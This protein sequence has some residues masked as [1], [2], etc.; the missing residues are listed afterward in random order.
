MQVPS[1]SHLNIL[2][3]E[4]NPGDLFL[5]EDMLRSTQLRI[6]HLY[7]ADRVQQA[8]E[9]I[10]NHSIHLVLLDLSLPDSSGL[11]SFMGIRQLTDK[12]PVII[13]TGLSD[14]NVALEA[15]KNGAQDYLIKGEFNKN[16]L[17]K[18]IQYSLER[19]YQ[20]ENLWQSNE[21]FN[22]VVRATN[23]AIWDRD[24]SANTIYWVGD[25]YKRLFGH[26]VLD[27][28]APKGQWE[29]FLHPD[30]QLRV[31]QK[32]SKTIR[33]GIG[34]TWEDLYRLRKKDGNYAYVHDR[35]YIIYDN[36]LPVRMIGSTQDI[37]ERKRV[38]EVVLASEAKYRQM[39]YR[40]PYPAWIYDAESL[41]ILEVND[42]AIDTYG[43][44]RDEF[45][46]LNLSNIYLNED[47]QKL[48][49]GNEFS[50]PLRTYKA[51]LWRHRKKSGET[52]IA[53]VTYYSI[54]YFGKNAVQEHIHDITEERRLQ[55][56][57]VRQQKIKRQQI[58]EAVLGAQEKE[59]SDIGRELHDNINQ[60]LATSKLYL[61]V[62]LEEEEDCNP[63]IKKSRKNITLAIE[64]I[65]KISKSLITPV[66]DDVGLEQSI[67][68]LTRNIHEVKKMRFTIDAKDL[69]EDLLTNDQKQ[70][71]YRIVQEQLNNILKHADAS[72][73]NIVLN[74]E[75]EKIF[76]FIEDNGKGFNVKNV[77]KG[78][79][80]T[81]MMSR[82]EVFNGKLEIDSLPGQ[83]CRLK[84][85]LNTKTV[86][87]QSSG[88]Q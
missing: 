88:L 30:D 64:E 56:Q 60:I 16:L 62:I 73:V 31:I 24:L 71:L 50:Y 6:D 5:V 65:R 47:L 85:I 61:D 43:Y 72:N 46:N 4:D 41:Q 37:T 70:A 25:S 82:A 39:F 66:L 2:T 81:N 59:R 15:I 84:V 87:P 21:R 27:D 35:G 75:G 86:M 68:E 63:L 19:K 67:K 48:T 14:A 3:V 74:T 13:L 53:E 8:C 44:S 58:T 11:D 12:I 69:D 38:E 49:E 32:L 20:M 51:K 23:D 57:L 40:N 80:I 45:M 55:K 10:E 28:F 83:G 34:N 79:G 76:L 1:Y 29:S 9:I 26:E 77:Q 22:M 7:S 18:S 42:A 52:L 17:T 54:D 36:D 33:E 78:V